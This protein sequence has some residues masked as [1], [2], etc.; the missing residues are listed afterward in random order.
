[1]NASCCAQEDCAIA[2]SL[3]VLEIPTSTVGDTVDSGDKNCGEMQCVTFQEDWLRG[4]IAS[5][6]RTKPRTCSGMF[7]TVRTVAAASWPM[8][9]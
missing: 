6:R 9:K 4:W 7:E 1:V 8:S 5:F 3:K 2:K